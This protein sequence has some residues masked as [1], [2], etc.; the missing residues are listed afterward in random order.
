VG[1][2]PLSYALQ[3]LR[4]AVPVLFLALIVLTLPAPY[5]Y[6]SEI[7]WTRFGLILAMLPVFFLWIRRVRPRI[8]SPDAILE[9]ALP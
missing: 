6:F 1:T 9:D 4:V 8:A 3:L 2:E 7:T 5:D